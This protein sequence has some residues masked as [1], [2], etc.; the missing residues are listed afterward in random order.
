MLRKYMVGSAG[1]T[2]KG[3]DC[4]GPL[5]LALVLLSVA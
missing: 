3:V 1:L 5:A 2:T 4:T